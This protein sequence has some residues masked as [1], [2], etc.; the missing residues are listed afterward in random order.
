M[1]IRFV[2]RYLAVSIAAVFVCLAAMVAAPAARAATPGTV[3]SWGSNAYGQLGDGTVVDHTSPQPVTT[4]SSIAQIEGG[5]EH[6]L[7]RT[8]GGDVYAWG[9]NRQGQAGSDSTAATVRTP[10]LVVS[11]AVDIGA[12]HYSSFAVTGDGTAWGWGKNTAGQLGDG[13]T[14]NRRAP[15]AIDGLSGVTMTQIAGGRDHAMALDDGGTV[16]T[17]GS[18]AYGQLGDG[19]NV[20][21]TMPKPV[22]GLPTI[23]DIFAGRDHC[24]AVSS[25]GEVWAWGRNGVGQVGSG[26]KAKHLSPVR[27][28]T[29]VGG[30]TTR[31]SGIVAVGAGAD[32]SLALAADGTLYAWG[33]NAYGQVGDGSFTARTTAVAIAVPA[34]VAA[35]AGGRQSTIAVTETGAVYTWGDGRAG[36]L[37]DGTTTGARSSPGVVS[38]LAG[39]TSVAMGRDFSLALA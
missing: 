23:V 21:R 27:V 8:S 25:D 10:K 4:L 20:S 39:I 18:N 34:P 14:T 15:V 17:W 31:L 22:L 24:L 28:K 7:A 19:T 5:R 36:Q 1:N 33:A 37:G 29:V 38:G 6:A 32:H 35:I 3:Q 30:T 2:S 12:G 13:T 26:N 11:D 9:W 16:Y